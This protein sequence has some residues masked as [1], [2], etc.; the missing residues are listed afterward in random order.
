MELEICTKMVKKMSEKLR[1]KFPAT[2]RGY[3][4]IKIVR[5]DDALLE[6]FLTASK[7]V[8]GQ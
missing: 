7:S 4:M 1:T 2:T 6:V 8:E 3:F 5:L